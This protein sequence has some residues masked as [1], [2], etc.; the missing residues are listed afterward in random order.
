VAR[1]GWLHIALG[2]D[3]IWKSSPAGES[4]VI[5]PQTALARSDR[6]LFFRNQAAFKVVTPSGEHDIA[7]RKVDEDLV[8]LALVT[9]IAA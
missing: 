4:I 8:W 6:K 2:A 5:P 1:G 7:I 9:T 3:I